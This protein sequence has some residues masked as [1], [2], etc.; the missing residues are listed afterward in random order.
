MIILKNKCRELYYMNAFKSVV[1][2]GSTPPKNDKT[3]VAIAIV[4]PPLFSY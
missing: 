4:F 2:N 3:A 1:T